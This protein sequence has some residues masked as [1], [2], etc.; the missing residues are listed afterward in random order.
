MCIVTALQDKGEVVAMTGDGVNDAPALS[1]ANIGISMGIAGTDVAK[2]ASDMVLQ[3]DNFANIVN[4][5]EEGRKIYSNIRN[6]VRYQVST[7]VAA[8][9]LLIIATLVFD[10]PL[11]LTAT[12][13]LV[14]NILMDGPPAVALGVEKSH[15]NVMDRP[16]RPVDESLPNLKDLILI[17]YLGA[18]MVIGTILVYSIA[19]ENGT[20]EYARTMCFSVFVLFQL[21]NVM[22]CRSSE[23]S[24]FK[25]GIFSNRAIY[26]AFLISTI[27]LLGIVQ[28]GSITIPFTDIAIRSLLSTTPL[29]QSD[30]FV[31]VFVASTVFV[32]EEFR[33]FMV[34]T[35]F[36]RVSTNRRV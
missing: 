34:N 4:A 35:G 33:K 36:F 12:Q 9:A 25:L 15:T 7:N 11:P 2:D 28:F 8:V 16:P 31:V 3:D 30:W 24:V 29:S 17:F 1:R 14:I 27:L 13:I 23:D 32:I 26:I 19:Y 22:N 5:V 21:F 20:K 18:V 6:F 10:L